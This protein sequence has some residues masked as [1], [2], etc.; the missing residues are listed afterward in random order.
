MS[1]HAIGGTKFWLN[2]NLGCVVY[3]FLWQGGAG[4]SVRGLDYAHFSKKAFLLCKENVLH[5]TTEQWAVI[6]ND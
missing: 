4:A 6:E 5:Q 2:W 3:L 1:K